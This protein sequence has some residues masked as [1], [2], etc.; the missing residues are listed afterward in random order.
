M[1]CGHQPVGGELAARDRQEAADPVALEVVEHR[2]RAADVARRVGVARLLV[3]EQRPHAGPHPQRARPAETGHEPLA[4]V[5]HLVDL[6]LGDR[7]LVGVGGAD[8]GRAD[9]AHRADRDEDVAVRGHD[10]PVDHR[11]HQAVVHGDHDPLAG[12][13]VD[14]LAAG[15]LRDLG[16]PGPG[17][18]EDE[19]GLDVDLLAG[20]LVAQARAA[21]VVALAPDADHRW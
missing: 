18:V 19:A 10:Q 12:G 21:D 1:S 16:D 6:V 13:D 14:A 15:H 9:H 2:V 7:Q 11:V 4:V 8:V 3:L 17:G 5:E 20:Q